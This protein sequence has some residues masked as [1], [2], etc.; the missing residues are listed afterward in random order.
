MGKLW[1]YLTDT[2]VYKLVLT[3]EAFK[4][5]SGDRWPGQGLS[6]STI[7]QFD[8]FRLRI[9][10]CLVLN[11][12]FFSMNYIGIYTYGITFLLLS[13][14][15]TGPWSFPLKIPLLITCSGYLR[16][17]KN[18]LNSSKRIINFSGLDAKTIILFARL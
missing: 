11:V 15:G 13:G 5:W 7:R 17:F 6:K 8:N 10:S 2:S 4:S 3:I 12:K 18:C 9:N 16:S 1:T 14:F